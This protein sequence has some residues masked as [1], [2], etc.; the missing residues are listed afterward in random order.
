M[1]DEGV[2]EMFG[3][4]VSDNCREFRIYLKLDLWGSILSDKI[5]YIKVEMSGCTREQPIKLH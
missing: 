2:R 5:R 1:G 3:F 4:I